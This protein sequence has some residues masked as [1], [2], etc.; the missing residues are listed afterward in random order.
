MYD[1]EGHGPEDGGTECLYKF[2]KWLLESNDPLANHILQWN[3][4]LIIPVLNVDTT[5]R[6]NMRRQYTLSNGTIISVP[7]GVDLSRNGIYGWGATGSADPNNNYEYRGLYAGSEPET[8]AYHNAAGRYRPD[9]YCNTH[10][11]G[12]YMSHMS[13]T[14]L[15]TRIESLKAQYEAQFGV[16]NPYPVN[17]IRGGG[18]IYVDVDGSFG[19]S[20]WLWEISTWENLKPT[21]RLFLFSLPLLKQLRK[22]HN[23]SSKT[24][25]KM[26]CHLGLVLPYREGK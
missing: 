7:Y 6:Q 1:G 2:C 8:M 14:A 26:A 24:D 17:R 25:L 18:Q 4:H 22:H 12:E 20:G 19:A 15:E 11:G 23:S 9:I 10:V 5:A 3:Y 16:V 21:Q 13:D